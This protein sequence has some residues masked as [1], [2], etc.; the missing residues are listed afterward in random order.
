MYYA[1]EQANAACDLPLDACCW[2]VLLL[3]SS[4]HTRRIIIVWTLLYILR[5]F[6]PVEC[7]SES[8]DDV[9]EMMRLRF[10]IE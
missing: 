7:E 10:L 8:D 1:N 2:R 5:A 3:I 9:K 4:S 6:F